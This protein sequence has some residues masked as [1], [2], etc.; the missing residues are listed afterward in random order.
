MSVYTPA[1][2]PVLNHT[3]WTAFSNRI[4]GLKISG[5][6]EYHNATKYRLS[7]CEYC[8]NLLLANYSNGIEFATGW[9]GFLVQG[10]AAV[11]SFSQEVNLKYGLCTPRRSGW[12]MDIENLLTRLPSLRT[13]NPQLV[14]LI[15]QEFG[16][17]SNWFPDFKEFRN[18]EGVHR[19]RISRNLIVTIGA[20]QHRI[21]I[22]GKDVD[23]YSVD[24][25]LKINDALESGYNLMK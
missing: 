1:T 15:K 25:I 21:Q 16:R 14:Q 18:S 19:T 3:N 8:A 11:D 4:S 2:L 23:V 24:T 7:I 13:Y 9:T 6:S 17:R 12:A 22:Q 5:L 10:K 20:P